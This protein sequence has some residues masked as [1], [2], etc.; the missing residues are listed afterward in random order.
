MRGKFDVRQFR[1]G[2]IILP[3]PG[4]P[5]PACGGSVEVDEA[6]QFDFVWSR[7]DKHLGKYVDNVAKNGALVR[8]SVG[9][10][11]QH[12][13]FGFVFFRDVPT[14]SDPGHMKDTLRIDLVEN[15]HNRIEKTI[16]RIV[17]PTIV[18]HR[19]LHV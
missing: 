12:F 6:G 19:M 14:S 8:P 4:D 18:V 3:Q 2:P 7:M 16:A 10:G 9:S 5:N 1:H 17:S 13:R 11:N 15:S